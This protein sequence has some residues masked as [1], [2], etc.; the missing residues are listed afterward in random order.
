ML[1]IHFVRLREIKEQSE[2]AKDT[3]K[4]EGTMV[5]SE[6]CVRGVLTERGMSHCA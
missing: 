1:D 5:F 2:I 4:N 3:R 6:G